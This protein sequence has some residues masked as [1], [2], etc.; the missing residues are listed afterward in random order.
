MRSVA[1]FSIAALGLCSSGASAGS[2]PAAIPLTI[3]FHFDAPY[4]EKSAREM[5]RELGALLTESHIQ[6]D[7]RDRSQVA[8]SDS[9]PNLVVLN[10]RGQCRME[11]GASSP[12]QPD[13]PLGFTYSSNGA[14]LPFSEIECDRVRAS[15]D[16]VMSKGDY[17]R[18]DKLLG[19]ALARVLAHELYHVLA[20]TFSHARTGVAEAAL[21]GSQLIADRFSLGPAELDRMRSTQAPG[22]PPLGGALAIY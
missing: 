2:T 9:F 20:R 18:R 11:P 6:V 12:A 10:F 14:V 3:V 16:S 17:G 8:A 21:S 22:K 15:V 7:W 19:R 13:Q 4:S 5:R 1:A